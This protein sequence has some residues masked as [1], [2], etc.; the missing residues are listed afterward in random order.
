VLLTRARYETV[1]WV[2]QGDASDRTRSPAELDA[3]AAY[4]EDCGVSALD[5][6][7]VAT[8]TPPPQPA[9]LWQIPGHATDP[10]GSAR[11]VPANQPFKG[12]A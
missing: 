9:L 12:P 2:P 3:I 8:A 5:D 1:I 4:L 6:L 7:P 10:P 11:P